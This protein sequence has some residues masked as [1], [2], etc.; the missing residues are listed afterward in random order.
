M[1]STSPISST[2]SGLA[3]YETPHGPVVSDRMAA[4]WC[5]QRLF[6]GANIKGVGN[7]GHIFEHP[8]I[9]P[10]LKM[11]SQDQSL[12][13]YEPQTINCVDG[14]RRA[15]VP[16]SLVFNFCFALAGLPDAQGITDTQRVWCFRAWRLALRCQPHIRPQLSNQM[17]C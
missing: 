1:A 17:E 9:A 12:L 8:D 3:M 14:R 6:S 13:R 15:T 10:L 16:V 11:S 2:L 7:M 4:G 5:L